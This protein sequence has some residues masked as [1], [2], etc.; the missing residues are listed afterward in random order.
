VKKK[1]ERT[2]KRLDGI[3]RLSKAEL[4]GR[5]RGNQEDRVFQITEG[6]KSFS[7]ASDE[8]YKLRFD[9]VQDA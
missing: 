8:Y 6:Y 2:V 3:P 5:P 7:R 1:R 4:N 9:E